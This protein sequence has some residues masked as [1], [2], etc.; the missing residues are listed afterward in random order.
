MSACQEIQ[1]NRKA[2]KCCFCPIPSLGSNSLAGWGVGI[3]QGA[4]TVYH[5]TV[6]LGPRMS[7]IHRQRGP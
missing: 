6:Y 3:A 2:G 1:G 5:M 4:G 7:K